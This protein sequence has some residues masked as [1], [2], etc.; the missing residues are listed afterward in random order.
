LYVAVFSVQLYLKNVEALE[1]QEVISEVR[2]EGRKE[3]EEGWEE[4]GR[5][6]EDRGGEKGR[7]VIRHPYIFN[8]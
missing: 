5:E 2:E 1:E 8:V 4:E 3:G 7:K 6:G